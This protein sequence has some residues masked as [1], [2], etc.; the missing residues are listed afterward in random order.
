VLKRA[1]YDELNELR[2]NSGGYIQVY[3]ALSQPESHLQAG[4]D[5]Q[6]SGRID[7]AWL[8]SLLPAADC[9]VYL[10]GPNSFMQSLYNNL[11]DSGI[12]DTQI[13]TEAFGPASL[14]RGNDSCMP[15]F[16]GIDAA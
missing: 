13:F 10:C 5:F 4:I 3:W 9:D 7:L 8:Q 15:A 11:R 1:F 6:H 14:V 12:K 16:T 2:K